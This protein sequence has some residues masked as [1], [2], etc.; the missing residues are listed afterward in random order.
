[1]PQS[2]KGRVFRYYSYVIDLPVRFWGPMMQDSIS[3]A[4]DTYGQHLTVVSQ[5]GEVRIEE[6]P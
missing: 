4:G 3:L 2:P 1:M 6:F 5:D